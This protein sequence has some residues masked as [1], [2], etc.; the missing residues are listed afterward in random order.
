MPQLRRSYVFQCSMRSLDCRGT[1]GER[2]TKLGTLAGTKQTNNIVAIDI[3]SGFNTP[4][5]V[6]WPLEQITTLQPGNTLIRLNRDHPDV[7]AQIKAQ[8]I[9]FQ[10]DHLDVLTKLI[11]HLH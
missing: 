8:S 11:Q 6:R 1:L 3:G 7:P 4:M 9:C 10:E 2:T 5:W